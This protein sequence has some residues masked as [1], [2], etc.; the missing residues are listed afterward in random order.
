MRKEKMMDKVIFW[1]FHGTLAYNDWMFSKALLKVLQRFEAD[2]VINL[3]DF[4]N[5]PMV[6]FP[7][8]DPEKEYLHL[9][10]GDAWWKHAEKI[11]ENCYRGLNLSEEMAANLAKM[12]R[13][14]L[15]RVDEFILYE[16]SVEMLKYF[17]DKGYSNVILSNHIPELPAIVEELGLSE[18]ILDCISSANIG[19]EKPNPKLFHYALEKYSHPN[20]V[21]MVGD[22]ITA[23]VKGAE[24][25]GIKGILVRSD[26]KAG[27]GRSAKDL[28]GLKEIIIRGGSLIESL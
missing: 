20:E 28:R 9:T 2:T 5:K 1:D 4:K 16:D 11:F 13:E 22:S 10:K 18:Y 21:W 23:D 27:V 14:E 15:I 6:G 8:Q 25:A 19:Y 26:Y 24:S 12:V 7:W 17:K 3:N